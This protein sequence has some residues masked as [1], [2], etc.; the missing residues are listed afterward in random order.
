MT[1]FKAK[2]TKTTMA[3]RL[4][5]STA[6]G[7]LCLP[8]VALAQEGDGTRRLEPV[9]VTAQKRDE[10]LQDAS[11]SLQVLGQETLEQQNVVEFEEY[12]ALLP[13]VSFDSI[14]PGAAQIYIRGVADGGD[15]NLSGSQPSVGLY[16]DEQPVTA[17]GRNLDVH[18]Y[19][20]DRIEVLGGPQGTL[21]GANA[22]AG[23]IRIITNAPDPDGFAAGYDLGAETVSEGDTGYIA[24]GFANIPLA[25]NAA[26]RLVG[27]YEQTAGY[28]DNVPA[29]KTFTRPGITVDNEPFVEEDFNVETTAGARAA[30]GIDIND[31][32]TVTAKVMH[33]QLE[34]EGVWDHDPEDVGDLEVERFFEDEGEDT[35][36]QYGATIEGRIGPV[37]LTYAASYLDREV[38]YQSDYSEYAEYSSYIDYYTC[39]YAYDAAV[40][41]YSFYACEDP[42]IQF[43]EMSEYKR[44]THELRFATDS[45]NRLRFIGGLFYQD[46]EVDFDQRWRIPTIK[47]GMQIRD[48]DSYFTTDQV[49]SETETAI[50]GEVSFDLTD[51]VTLTAGGRAFDTESS[52]VGF[53]GTVFSSSP[54]VDVNTDESGSLFKLK[55]DWQVSEDV[56]LYA[57]VSEGFRPGGVNR[58]STSNIPITY[59]SDLITNW[60]GGWKTE[61]ANNQLRLNGA[62]FFMQWEDIQFTRFDPSESFL[63]LTQNAGEAEITG[64]EVDFTWLATDNFTV[65]GAATLLDAALS[66]DFFQDASAG[67]GAMPDAPSGTRLPSVPEYKAYVSG[68][69]EAEWRDFDT[70]Y[71]ATYSIVGP[72]FNDLFLASR[73]EQDGYGILNA[74]AGF[75]RDNWRLSFFANNITDERAELFRNAVDF[76]ARITTNRPRSFGLRLSQDF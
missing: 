17:I 36:T 74:S 64:L 47:P 61:L 12:V 2:P 43:T 42:R 27:Y 73:E 48:P 37:D 46:A 4:L 41:G 62:V 32:W 38:E 26:L 68:R 75:G 35:F 44:E 66:E 76:D 16:L 40:G 70:F 54:E 39:Y 34:T 3:G 7:A 33:Q 22:Q 18:I 1:D 55:A 71:S 19:D 29:T 14:R 9:Q 51:A 72:R 20:I 25:S 59:E 56:L 11:I 57:T 65:S 58:T 6:L 23:T 67:P 45:T 5:A 60:E 49:R 13:S 15:G 50:F 53:V 10:T 63:G 21:Y 8:G 30:L 31:A 69:Y 28:I 52:I 24:E